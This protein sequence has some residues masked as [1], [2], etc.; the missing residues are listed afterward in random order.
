MGV[1]LG[2]C[3]IDLVFYVSLLQEKLWLDI[4]ETKSWKMRNHWMISSSLCRGGRTDEVAPRP[5]M[6]EDSSGL[7]LVVIST[8]TIDQVVIIQHVHPTD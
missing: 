8:E 2:V 1:D 4:P 5:D 6:G 7:S 3:S